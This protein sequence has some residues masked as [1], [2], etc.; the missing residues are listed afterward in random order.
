MKD[1]LITTDCDGVLLNFSR[2]MVIWAATNHG[3]TEVAPQAYSFNDRFGIAHGDELIEEF[4]KTLEHG[5][6][7]PIYS[8][9]ES[10]KRL[11]NDHGIQQIVVTAIDDFITE[12]RTKNLKKYYG[13]AIKEVHCTGDSKGKVKILKQYENSGCLWIEDWVA[14]A[15]MGQELGLNAVIMQ[16]PWNLDYGGK[17]P[18]FTN[19][20]DIV[21]YYHENVKGN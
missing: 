7:E 15:Y 21:S 6:I 8:S 13:D 5:E 12:G 19:M 1:T 3:L 14:N 2:S 4:I 17:L 10:V 20:T 9:I 11:Y 16:Q 18:V